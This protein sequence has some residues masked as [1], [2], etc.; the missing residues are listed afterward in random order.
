[1]FEPVIHL[2]RQVATP[3]LDIH[4]SLCACMCVRVC[5]C[6]CVCV[7]TC[8]FVECECVCACVQAVFL[9]SYYGLPPTFTGLFADKSIETKNWHMFFCVAVGLWGGLIIGVV[10]ER[11]TSNAY[12]PVQVGSW[13]A[14][15]QSCRPQPGFILAL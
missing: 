13:C 7:C 9:V 12:A 2:F 1:M 6:T 14:C 4:L 15:A 10:T 11:Y 5:A 3:F 8:V